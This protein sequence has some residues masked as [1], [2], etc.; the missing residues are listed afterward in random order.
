MTLAQFSTAVKAYFY[1]LMDF[2]F[3]FIDK[4]TR[5]LVKNIWLKG[6]ES[7]AGVT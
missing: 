3:V 7:C 2:R 5:N 4:N 1:F 6:A